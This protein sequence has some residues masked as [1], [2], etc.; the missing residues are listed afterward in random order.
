ME[1]EYARMLAEGG[2]PTHMEHGGGGDVKG[3]EGV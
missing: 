2:E 1:K 3:G